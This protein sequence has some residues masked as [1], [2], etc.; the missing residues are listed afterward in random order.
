MDPIIKPLEEKDIQ[1]KSPFWTIGSG[2]FSKNS[3]SSDCENCKERT[4][5]PEAQIIFEGNTTTYTDTVLL[6]KI[7]KIVN[8][9]DI[10]EINGTDSVYVYTNQLEDLRSL[11]EIIEQLDRIESSITRIEP[12][13]RK[14]LEELREEINNR[15]NQMESLIEAE[16]RSIRRSNREQ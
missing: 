9:I 15:M 7:Q 2:S 11:D 12:N 1:F 10:T 13:L 6:K 16:S 8:D 5:V 14:Q 3:P 4:A